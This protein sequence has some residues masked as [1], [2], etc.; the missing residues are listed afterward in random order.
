MTHVPITSLERQRQKLHPKFVRDALPPLGAT[1]EESDP[2]AIAKFF[3]PD[4]NWT[5]LAIE[6]DGDDTF[7]GLVHGIESE[8]G[9]FSLRELLRVRG[10][11]GLPVER[12]RHFEPTPISQLQS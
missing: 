4:G 9:Y 5:W 1:S 7:Y 10:A 3:T 12:D 11:L 8:I 6:F 2:K